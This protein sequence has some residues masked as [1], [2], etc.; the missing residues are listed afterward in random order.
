MSTMPLATSVFPDR[1]VLI[2]CAKENKV[3]SMSLRLYMSVYPWRVSVGI[4]SD[5]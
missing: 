1:P 4:Q 5:A 3:L 2:N